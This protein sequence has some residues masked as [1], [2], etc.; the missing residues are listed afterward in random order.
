LK[1][2]MPFLGNLVS[3]A[4]LGFTNFAGNFAEHLKAGM[5]DW[6]T[7]SLEGVY[8]PKA[9]TLLELG[10][11]ALSVLGITWAQIRGKIV[12]VLGPNGEMIMKGLET[13]FDIVVALV[14]GGTAAAWELIKEKL[15]DLKDQV[16]NGIIDFVLDTIV[17]KAIPKLI[18][19]F[20]PGAGFIPA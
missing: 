4:K 11:F 19:M 18:G 5:I 3:A 20:I 9:L 1:N 14:Q 15:N 16:I 10:K 12:K 8:I 13:A 6:L 2:P 7:G 17:K